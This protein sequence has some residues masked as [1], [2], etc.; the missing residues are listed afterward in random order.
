MLTVKMALQPARKSD[1][2]LSRLFASLGFPLI[3]P[4]QVATEDDHFFSAEHS[5]RERYAHITARDGEVGSADLNFAGLVDC[6]A[7]I[8]AARPDGIAAVGQ[9]FEAGVGECGR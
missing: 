3:V 5:S 9:W 7:E 2:V 6:A 8:M 1:G 4:H